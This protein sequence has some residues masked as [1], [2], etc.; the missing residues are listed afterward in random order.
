MNFP[1]YIAGRYLRSASKNNAINIIN[2]IASAGII[3]GAAALFV[4]LSVF[5]GLVKFS[6]S[7]INTIDPDISV[8][9]ST[10]KSLVLTPEQ[11]ERIKAINGVAHYTK[12]IEERA[13]FVFNGKEEVTWLKGVDSVYTN[14]STIRK[15]LM[16]GEWL[17]PQTYQCV[18]GYGIADK[19]SMGLFD[20]RNP[21]EV[22]MPKPGAGL[23]ENPNDAFVRT[24]LL[25]SAIYQ[26]N[27]EL[28]S[29]YV[30]A[31]IEVARQLLAFSPDQYTGVEVSLRP[32]ADETAVMRA[33]GEVFDQK[34]KVRTRAQLNDSLYKMLQ[35]ENLVIY[36]IFTLVII[37]ILFA[38]SGAI[39]MMILDKKSNLKTLYSLGTEVTELRKIFLFQGTLLCFIGGMIGLAIGS[40]IVL[41]QEHFE[42]VMITE[43]L[44]YPVVFTLRN[45]L[46]VI[47]TITSLGFLASLIASGRVNKSLLES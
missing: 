28:D 27:E 8:V 42:L 44:A 25:P 20:M 3:V 39:I 34:V 29:K 47:V 2:R 19:L 7:F 14:V 1:L 9:A 11:E 40:A 23:I 13:L 32:G 16:S 24:V 30:F 21:L 12:V 18:I 6:L 37:L 10:G 5:S 46:I 15:S 36:L 22:Y 38:F 43:T 26:I 17:A 35:A 31:D 41:A 33:L 4:V 45:L